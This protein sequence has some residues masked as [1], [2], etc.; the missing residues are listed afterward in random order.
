MLASRTV[1][2]TIESVVAPALPEP[3]LREFR[4]SAIPD[5][6]TLANIEILS[7]TALLEE[8]TGPAL[9]Q[10]GGHSQQYCTQAVKKI[11]AKYETVA[12]GGAWVCY[13]QTL[14]GEKGSI[15]VIKPFRP[16]RVTQGTGI[17]QKQKVIKYETPVGAKG[18]P[19]LPVVPEKYIQLIEQRFGVSIRRDIP[20][21]QAVLANPAILLSIHEGPKKALTAIAQG[22]P[23]I[24]IR[25]VTMWRLK[26]TD[27]L[28]A[29][30]L[31][32]A[33]KGRRIFLFF[34][35]DSAPKTRRNVFKQAVKLG[36][37][38]TRHGCD[39]R[40]V[41]WEPTLG[42]GID[43]VLFTIAP[44]HRWEWL[45]TLL[46]NTRNIRQLNREQ[47]V[48]TALTRL[49]SLQKLTYPVERHTEGAYLPELPALSSHAI[50]GLCAPMNSG[51]TYRIGQDW[52]SAWKAQREH[53]VIVL[54]PLNSLGEQTAKHWGL[55]HIHSFPNSEAGQKG[56]EACMRHAG[57][58]VLCPDSLH[59]L[60]EWVWRQ[61]ILLVLDEANQV[62]EH[63]VRGQTLGKRWSWINCRFVE[64][65]QSAQAIVASEANLPDRA[66]DLLKVLSKKETVRLFTHRKHQQP[67]QVTLYTGC[68]QHKSGFF[69]ELLAQLSA[70]HKLMFVS[71]S[72][73]ARQR[74]EGMV[75][76]MLPHLKVVR[77]DS[78]TNEGSAFT[79]FFED[80]DQWL[81]D[82]QPDILICSP[83][84]KSGVS[85]QGGL[86]PEQA[87]F[88]S[89]WGYFP[90]GTTDI[91]LQ[92]LGRFRP[93][94]PRHIYCPPVVFSDSDESSLYPQAIGRE[95][96]KEAQALTQWLGLSHLLD[97]PDE[98]TERIQTAIFEF[99]AQS[100]AVHSAMRRASLDYLVQ[101][102]Q[103]DGHQVTYQALVPDAPIRELMETV[104]RAIEYQEAENLANAHL[105]P[106]HTVD[107]AQQTL[108]SQCS[109]ANRYRARKVLLQQDFPGVDFNDVGICLQA[110][111]ENYSAL[112]KGVK[113]QVHA[114]NP[115][116]VKLQDAYKVREI[117]HNQTLKG[118]HKLPKGTI[119]AVLI[120]ALRV[121][122]LL[123][124]TYSNQTPLVQ[125]IKALA[126]Q[127]RRL[128][129]RYLHLHI[130]PEQTGVHIVNKLL[131]RLGLEP[132]AIA[133]PGTTERE[134]V[135]QVVSSELR[136]A[137]L[138]AYRRRLD[139]LRPPFSSNNLEVNLNRGRGVS[140]EL[141]LVMPIGVVRS[142]PGHR[143]SLWLPTFPPAPPDTVVPSGTA[144]DLAPLVQ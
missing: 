94:V 28:S 101:R 117:L 73:F 59:R 29:E 20:F 76:A 68:S 144:I 133:R 32:F 53:F 123:D 44:E 24:A 54:T 74:L 31:P 98:A 6:L 135:Y 81:Q 143:Q 134:R 112:I 72:K 132:K 61:Q 120:Q 17:S 125:E 5:D 38:F 46:D 35:Q 114:E 71:S 4:A 107:W 141:P 48:E 14:D 99:Y 47:A 23:A 49:E 113:L 56:L 40:A 102:L 57:G 77:I 84:V 119:C 82:Q 55:P 109:L 66:L 85:I 70:G 108:Q 10:L 1:P 137:L 88:H 58:L 127:H 41:T 106:E 65:A 25:G 69:A 104:H 16:R 130:K 86:P 27:E 97:I 100:Y 51:K 62:L 110:V 129:E 2:Q 90:S 33:Q 118:I 131:R 45:G 21:W 19:I 64:L 111:V 140:T 37:A 116:L 79:A 138:G 142:T 121:L 67:W 93:A 39:F 122:E 139:S 50:H 12:A 11:L 63:L 42:K 8:L 105:E 26:G 3:V 103:Q 7:G 36:Q 87:Y 128:I 126:L 43:D 136:T 60:P 95:L 115:E 124:K 91:H 96:R 9:S 89:V 15:P 83:S 13:G 92:L 75:Q 78:D 22:L 80:P 52:V 30:L 34:D 18:T